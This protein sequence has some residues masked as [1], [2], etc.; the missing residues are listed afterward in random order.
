MPE[1]ATT[2]ASLIGRITQRRGIRQFIKFAIV[3]TSGFA[4]N[5]GVFTILQLPLSID[6]R[7]M[8]YYA[9]FS[10]AFMAGGVSNYFLNRVWTFRSTGHAL[11]E[12]AKFLT[13]SAI[14]LCVS[15]IVS[16]A[17][18]PMLGKGHKLWFVSTCAG[19]IV[20]FFVNKYWTFRSVL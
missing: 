4:V 1:S 9:I 8:W 3:G 5:G 18:S 12:G 2:A 13:V 16:L 10:I 17:A 20:N 14:A 19:I 7:Q 15:L 11:G 6:Q